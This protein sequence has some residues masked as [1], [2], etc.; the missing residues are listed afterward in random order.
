[1]GGSRLYM[2]MLYFERTNWEKFWVRNR[3][4]T[5]NIQSYK[6][7][8]GHVCNVIYVRCD[9]TLYISLLSAPLTTSCF[10]FVW[11]SF[12][13]VA[14]LLDCFPYIGNMLCCCFTWHIPSSQFSC[15]FRTYN[16]HCDTVSVIVSVMCIFLWCNVQAM[17]LWLLCILLYD[18]YMYVFSL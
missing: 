5:C 7:S 17:C 10:T 6:S 18:I 3:W 2:F 12:C 14:G 8:E 4:S 1:M 9:V 15:F 13:L 11:C 16:I